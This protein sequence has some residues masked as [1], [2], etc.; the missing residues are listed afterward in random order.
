M[1]GFSVS[2]LTVIELGAEGSLF[3]SVGFRFLTSISC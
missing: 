1:Y 3:Q 2:V